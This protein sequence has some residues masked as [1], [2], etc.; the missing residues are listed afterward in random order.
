[1]D[2]Q[3]KGRTAVVTGASQGLGRAIAVGLALAVGACHDATTDPAA[4]LRAARNSAGARW[5]ASAP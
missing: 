3:L 4:A 1:M 2:L 5:Q